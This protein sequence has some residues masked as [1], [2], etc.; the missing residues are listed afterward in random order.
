[1]AASISAG[2]DIKRTI[3]MIVQAYMGTSNAVIVIDPAVSAH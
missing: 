2:S 1:M 3:A